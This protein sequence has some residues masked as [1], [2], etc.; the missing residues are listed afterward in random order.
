MS[1]LSS[2][3]ADLDFLFSWNDSTGCQRVKSCVNLMATC[4]FCAIHVQISLATITS[5]HGGLPL[6]HYQTACHFSMNGLL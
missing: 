5:F 3:C 4:E 6:N 2:S 1:G